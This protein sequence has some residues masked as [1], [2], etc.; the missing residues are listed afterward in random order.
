MLESDWLKTHSHNRINSN[1]LVP[2][3]TCQT[4]ITPV[5]TT[6]QS[7]QVTTITESQWPGHNNDPV[8]TMTQSQQWSSHN[9]DPVTTMIQS[10][11]WSSHN[12]DPSN[13]TNLISIIT[14]SQ[15]S[16][17]NQKWLRYSNAPITIKTQQITMTKPQKGHTKQ[18]WQSF[19]NDTANY[20]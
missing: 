7:Q 20:N 16:P 15:Q 12:K 3:I 2:T 19:N 10:Q 1:N 11:Q 4:K 5:T 6:I 18:Q 13:S 9:N 8:T 17:S 14:Q